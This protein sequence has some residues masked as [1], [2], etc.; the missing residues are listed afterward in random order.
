MKNRTT[1]W[2]Y[3]RGAAGAL[4]LT[5]CLSALPLWA[6][7]QQ[8]QQEDEQDAQQVEQAA[9]E[10]APPEESPAPQ[11]PEYQ[12]VPQRLT[13][14]AGTIVTIRTSQ[15]LSSDESRAGDKFTAELDQPVVVDGWVLARRGQTVIGRVAVAQKAGRAKGTSQLG[16]EL[17]QL[18]LVDGQQIPVRSQLLQTSAGTSQGRDA[19]AVGT[20][21]G[22]GAIVGA[23]ADGGK[24]AG[25]GAA[26]GAGAG[27]AGILLTRGRPTE[28]PPETALTFELEY[29]VTVSTARSGPAF[30]P[31]APEDYN[32]GSLRRRTDHFASRPQRDRPSLYYPYGPWG[33]GYPGPYFLSVTSYGGRW[34]HRG[35][36]FGH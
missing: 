34:G 14:P 32:G 13:L 1:G 29:P 33:Y 22:I 9:D 10:T 15:F 5:L 28:I 21:T 11:N 16:V 36:H 17:S 26:I 23:A 7:S 30:R 2:V 31:V 35:R 18:V 24:G 19:Q 8:T 20:S 27:L 3:F 4:A 12:R 25:I 6:Q